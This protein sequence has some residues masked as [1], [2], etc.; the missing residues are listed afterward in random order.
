MA[1]LL[2]LTAG[3][4]DPS[5]LAGIQ[6]NSKTWVGS[7]DGSDIAVGIVFARQQAVV[8]FCGGDDSYRVATHW[9]SGARAP[10]EPFTLADASWSVSGEEQHGVLFGTVE[11]AD[12]I[13]T[14][15]AI[16]VAPGTLAGVYDARSPCGHVGLIVRQDSPSDEPAA[17][18]TCLRVIAR[19]VVVE[20]VNPVVPLVRDAELGILVMVPATSEVLTVHPLA[21][22]AG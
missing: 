5:P 21:P 9:F 3:C 7:V 18:G 17:Q 10:G 12:S 6:T 4:S 16:P 11:N 1:C 14:F 2:T 13:R 8:F 15:S 22:G 20:Q 19:E